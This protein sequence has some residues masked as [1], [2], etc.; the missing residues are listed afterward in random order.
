MNWRKPGLCTHE[1]ESL[2]GLHKVKHQETKPQEITWIFI[3][4]TRGNTTLSLLCQLLPAP[5][6]VIFTSGMIGLS[7]FTRTRLCTAQT[8][9]LVPTGPLFWLK[10]TVGVIASFLNTSFIYKLGVKGIPHSLVNAVHRKEAGNHEPESGKSPV[11]DSKLPSIF[12][13]DDAT[14]DG[15]LESWWIEN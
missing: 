2:Q 4:L 10:K 9:D 7:I 12:I 6:S 14:R 1:F 3:K 8:N 15:Y 11:G 5:W 13:V